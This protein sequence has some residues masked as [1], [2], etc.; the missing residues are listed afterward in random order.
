MMSRSRGRFLWP[1]A[2]IAVA[3][4]SGTGLVRAQRGLEKGEWPE[5]A[6]DTRGLKYSP[7][8]Q[9]NKA[10]IKDL[11]VVW[12]WASAD[13]GYQLANPAMR[14]TRHE[15]TPLVVKGVMYTVTPLGMVAALDP[16][17][18][19]QRWMYDPE[20]YKAGKP[21]NSG[22]IHR[23]LAYWTD[24][25]I[26]RILHGTNDAYL[27][28]IDTRTGMPDPRFGEAGRVDLTEIIPR[29]VRSTNFMGRRPLVAGNVIVVGNAIL[30]P[31]RT[32]EMPPGYVQAFD[33]RSGKRL[34]T[35]HTVP[36]PGEFGY[37]TWLGDSAEY[38][39]NT[40]VW[41]GMTYDPELDYVYMPVSGATN[42]SWGGN[43]LGNNL[44]AETLVCV[45]AKTG[46]RVWHFQI[47]HHG[48]WD[49]DLP[50]HPILGDITVDGRRIKAVIQ[51]TKQ[52]FTFAFDRKTGVPVWP[53]EERPVPQ[54]TVPGERTS[55]TQPFPVKPPPFAL[56]GSTEE[57]V[58]DFTPTL[59]KQA[60]ENLQHFVHGPIYTP[61][62]EKGTLFLPGVFGGANWGGGAFDPETG[63]LYVPS[64]M[65]PTVYRGAPLVE[66]P[67]TGSA[68]VGGSGGSSGG[69]AVNLNNLMRI[70]GLYL[71][72]PPY[73]K[74]TAID[75][76][77]GETL[78][79][80]PI[81]NGPRNHPLLKGLQLPPLGDAIER[82]GVMVTRT[83]VFVNAQRLDSLGRN[84]PPPWKEWGDPDMDSR[85]LYV[86]DKQTGALIR[87]IQLDGLSAA[88]P[89]TYMIGGKQYIALAT[90]GGETAE[91][92]ALTLP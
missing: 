3:V 36:K 22:F 46:R 82:L 31:T 24:G 51:V 4:M 90:G 61:P 52:G 57:N 40:N 48:I 30:D 44:F 60:L 17:T 92:A 18:G 9:I 20:V 59:K 29:A 21:G 16:A 19:Q 65:T 68:A 38:S 8:D 34:W 62:S 49:Y 41:A 37:D 58:I 73:S 28:S 87:E 47:D 72:K 75:M 5:Y 80:T 39:G 91:I 64:R 1:A 76:N 66:Q 25:K 63:I 78:W 2:L 70:E 88:I 50:A 56:Q 53:I 74:I 81:G 6:G 12:R 13:R 83:L 23:G 45:E 77:R 7:L 67:R 55:P 84:I 10:N 42:E 71:F 11:R 33:V 43:R 89:M 85:L 54:S 26:E 27:I 15:D 86:F 32:K 69:S 14:A 35:F 79:E